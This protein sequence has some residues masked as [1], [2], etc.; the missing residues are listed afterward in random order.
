MLRNSFTKWL[1]D[2]RRS[3][4]TWALA[5]AGVGA[6]YAAFWPTMD[7]PAMRELLANYADE[8]LEALNYTDVATAAGYLNA[9][10]YGLVGAL[11]T[12][13]FSLSAGAKTIAGD[14]EAGTLDL[15]LA[16]PITRVK[17]ALQR[18]AA[19]LLVAAVISL[20]ML[21]LMLLISGPAHLEEISVASYLAMHLHLFLFASLFGAVGFGVGAA[22]GRRGLALGVGAAFAVFGFAA[23]GL[24][25]QIDGLEWIEGFSPFHWLNGNSPLDNGVHAGDALIMA[26]LTVLLVAMGL[27]LLRRRDIAV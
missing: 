14:E 23:N 16:H 1:W 9:T 4:I 22:T 11:L 3:M 18:F 13:V 12:V 8:L 10:V 26:G 21:V 19:F 15:V 17:L 2:N 6:M 20:T 27:L 7:N 24:F 25:N 5:I